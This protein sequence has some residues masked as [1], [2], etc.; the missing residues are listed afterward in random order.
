LFAFVYKGFLI[1]RVRPPISR[2]RIKARLIRLAGALGLESV[3][4]SGLT[5]WQSKIQALSLRWHL[6]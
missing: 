6:G 4:R 2:R 3:I 5:P 1:D